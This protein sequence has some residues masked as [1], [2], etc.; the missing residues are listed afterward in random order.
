MPSSAEHQEKY[1]ENRA[2]LDANGGLAAAQPIWASVVAFYAALH[3][4]E[5]LAA[6]QNIHHGNHALRTTYLS[7]HRLHRVIYP[8]FE[9]LRNASE[10]ARYGTANQFQRLVPTANVQAVLIDKHLVAI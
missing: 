6:R 5:R 1:L 7:R 2:F 8:A 3:L 9:A 4:D 10:V